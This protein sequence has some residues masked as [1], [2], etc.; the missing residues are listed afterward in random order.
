MTVSQNGILVTGSVGNKFWSQVRITDIL[1]CA[2]KV[3]LLGLL[4]KKSA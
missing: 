3:I 1:Y 4:D 2:K